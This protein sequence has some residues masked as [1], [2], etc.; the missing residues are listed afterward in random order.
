MKIC[1]AITATEDMGEKTVGGI[2]SALAGVSEEVRELIEQDLDQKEMGLGACF[3][4]IREHARKN[5]RGSYWAC[6]VWGIDPENEVVKVIL[7][8]YKIPSDWVRDAGVVDSGKL[9]VESEGANEKDQ[10]SNVHS[11]LSTARG[12]GQ[13]RTRRAAD[14]MEL[15]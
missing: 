13:R 12:G 6:A 4:A 14:L 10:L 7:D 2:L 15:I 1:D 11:Q 5:Q 8:F 9:T 3:A